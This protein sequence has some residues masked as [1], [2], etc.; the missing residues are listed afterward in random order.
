MWKHEI[1]IATLMEI[2]EG[3]RQLFDKT[4]EKIKALEDGIEKLSKE[5]KIS[6]DSLKVLNIIRTPRPG[7]TERDNEKA[8]NL[9]RKTAWQIEIER[10]IQLKHGS[11]RKK[12]KKELEKTA[13]EILKFYTI[14]YISRIDAEKMKIQM[15]GK[16]SER[17][18]RKEEGIDQEIEQ[19]Q[20]NISGGIELRNLINRL[21][22]SG[23]WLLSKY[24]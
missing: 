20:G 7:E 24:D 22:K 1:R 3:V 5:A 10:L 23:Y 9:S 16:W 15:E 14:L 8:I 12:E 18:Q 6:K 19:L 17:R 11:D 2:R 13:K 4:S 21:L